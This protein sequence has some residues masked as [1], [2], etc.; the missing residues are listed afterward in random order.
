MS[1]AAERCSAFSFSKDDSILHFFTDLTHLHAIVSSFL[2]MPPYI[3]GSV[4]PHERNLLFLFE[5]DKK[6]L[7]VYA[8]ILLR[9]LVWR[10]SAKIKDTFLTLQLRER[11]CC[12]F[13]CRLC[14]Q[15]VGVPGYRTEIYCA[16]CEVRTE[17]IYV[18]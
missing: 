13:C 14:G 17:F 4:T 16:S 9:K 12:C 10:D 1:V 6:F 8:P 7:I 11:F 5:E 2:S 3:L 15:V 18:M